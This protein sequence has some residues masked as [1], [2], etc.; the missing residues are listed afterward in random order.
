VKGFSSEVVR[1]RFN[2]DAKDFDAIYRLERSPFWRTVNKTLRKAVFDRYRITF[3]R[4]GDVTGKSIL[5]IGCGS[6]VYSVDFARR[7]ARRVVGIDFS[8]KMLEI[9]RAEAQRFNVQDRCQFVQGDFRDTEFSE[10][11]DI[12]IAMG[13]FDYLAEP[14]P[15]IQRMAGVTDGLVLASFP[16]PSLIRGSLRKL[17]YLLSGRG[18]VRYYDEASMRAVVAAAGFASV[19]L[20][21]LRASGGGY[22]VAGSPL[23][24]SPRA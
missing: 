15:F 3:E 17:R 6:G 1:E 11:F 22:V 10:R 19:E 18:S 14:E 7:G 9:A 12:S 20:I 13:V 16:R 24:R 2:R 5:D 8:A 23:P 4:S 21:P